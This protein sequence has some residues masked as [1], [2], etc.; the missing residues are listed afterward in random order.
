MA[1]SVQYL[2]N[3]TISLFKLK[4]VAG[5]DGLNKYV[6]W[7]CY[8]EDPDTIE[9]IRGN[10]LAITT[11]LNVFR[12]SQNTDDKSNEY[13]TEFL[14]RTISELV[15]RNASGLIVNVGKYINTIPVEIIAL[16]DRLQ[17]PLFTMPWEIHTIDLM[18]EVCNKIVNDNQKHK[19]LEQNFYE[20]IF[21][22]RSFEVSSLEN[23]PFANTNEFSVILMEL[24]EN[25]FE[26]DN[27]QLKR[28]VDYSFN[29]KIGLSPLDFCWF[30]YN[31][32]V[33]YI[34]HTDGRDTA[35]LMNKIIKKDRHFTGARISVSDLC[36]SYRELGAVFDHADFALRFCSRQTTLCDYS[37]LGVYKIFAEVKDLSVLKN[38]YNEVLGK[39]D[40]LGKAKRDDYLATLKL[41]ADFGGRIQKTAEENAAHRNT[42]NYRIHRI[43]EILG[44]DLQDSE[45]M[46][47][48]QTA[49]HIKNLLDKLGE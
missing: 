20:A 43:S 11:G 46:Y 49:L 8:T 40:S 14:S 48:I 6:S 19:T 18:Q 2:Y 42:V 27:D 41:Y 16:C 9:F 38:F 47:R 45:T 44:V 34:L 5:K 17:F 30:L 3:Y 7:M 10:E 35:A 23:T 37:T 24:P 1:L 15:N 13:I 32:K 39:L 36:N 21:R 31:G 29:P 33:V 28:Y 25:L 26:N 12:H 4:L 22:P